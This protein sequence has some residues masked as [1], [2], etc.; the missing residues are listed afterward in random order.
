[1]KKSII[2]SIG[3][4][5]ALALTTSTGTA[6]AAENSSLT[7]SDFAF[8]S[9]MHTHNSNVVVTA[10]GVSIN[11]VFYTQQEFRSAL[12]Q[13]VMLCS[14][15]NS[16]IMPRAAV[17]ALPGLYFIP[18]IGQVAIAAT[19]AIVVAGVTI[20]V[21]SW[22]WNTITSWLADSH[23]QSIA[24][25]R[26]SIPS[27]LKKSNGDV[28]L[29]KFTKKQKGRQEWKAD[30]GWSIDKDTAGHGGRKW[31]LK[32]KQGKRVASLGENGEVL[33]D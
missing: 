15:Y 27:Q 32:N 6:L 2:R 14:T 4:T 8:S 30:N 12:D 19:G 31:K 11:G 7:N 23:S 21:G 9:I 18:G 25:I 3:F 29:G 1:M 24:R 5:V 10:Q 16:G 26:A 33:G 22:L 17:A 13:A 20:S 28:N